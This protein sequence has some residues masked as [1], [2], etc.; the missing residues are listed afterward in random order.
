MKIDPDFVPAT[1]D[2]AIDTIIKTLRKKDIKY[3]QSQTADSVHFSTG[4]HLRNNWSLWDTTTPLSRDIQ[5]KYDIWGHGDDISS[6]ILDGVW[7]K[8]RGENIEAKLNKTVEEIK[9]HWEKFGVDWRTGKDQNE[10]H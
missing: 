6:L 8:V 7:A 10:N 9:S 2:E 3:I 4:M 1:L 5:R